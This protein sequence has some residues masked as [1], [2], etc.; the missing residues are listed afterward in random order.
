M[1]SIKASVQS[2]DAIQRVIGDP[3]DRAESAEVAK[4]TNSGETRD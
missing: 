4:R 2:T 1:I 3:P